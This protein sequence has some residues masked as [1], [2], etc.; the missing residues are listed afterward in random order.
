MYEGDVLKN[1]LFE[2]EPIE[3]CKQ[4]N[5]NLAI[6]YF[7]GENRKIKIMVKI[8]SDKIYIVTFYILNKEQDRK[9]GR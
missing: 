8:S 1:I 9:V 5:G 6:I 7:H 4:R 2:K 3:I